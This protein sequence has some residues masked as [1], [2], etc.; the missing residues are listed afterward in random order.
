MSLPN[1]DLQE[2]MNHPFSA[3]NASPEQLAESKAAWNKLVE[4]TVNTRKTI[5]IKYKEIEEAFKNSKDE[6]YHH[7]YLE[8]QMPTLYK[9]YP[10]LEG[11]VII[12]GP[13]RAELE[14]KLSELEQLN[15]QACLEYIKA[16]EMARWSL[17]QKK[18]CE[19]FCAF[20]EKAS[21]EQLETAIMRSYKEPAALKIREMQQ[22]ITFWNVLAWY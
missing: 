6:L 16:C 18:T 13:S 4:M 7:I 1:F 19:A 15:D 5:D 9:S 8:E 3:Y 21:L 14:K 17:F 20:K 2:T 22:R 10:K 11:V 12:T